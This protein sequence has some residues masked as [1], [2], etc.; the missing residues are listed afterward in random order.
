MRQNMNENQSPQKF[1]AIFTCSENSE[2]HQ[3]W[4]KLSLEE[5]QE[6]LKNGSLALERWHQKYFKKI[7]YQKCDLDSVTMQV[8]KAGI[9]E[10][11]SQMGGFL[12]VEAGSKQEAAE[13]FLDHPHFSLF[14]G[15][16]VDILEIK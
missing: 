5:K 15:D 13:M 2:N 8:S 16:S 11:P 9:Q 6:R 12:M 10:V 3:A 14:P 4:M 1:L 7:I